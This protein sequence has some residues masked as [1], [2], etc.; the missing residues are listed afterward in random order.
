MPLPG[1]SQAAHRRTGS[2]GR[3][4]TCAPGC[5]GPSAG[6][7]ARGTSPPCSLRESRAAEAPPPAQRRTQHASRRLQELLAAGVLPAVRGAVSCSS[8]LLAISEKRAGG[9][10]QAG[11][12]GVGAPVPGA[13]AAPRGRFVPRPGPVR[14]RGLHLSRERAWHV[15][16]APV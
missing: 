3:A 8:K 13:R 14:L 12:G 2:S 9:G 6:P 15:L 10:V 16:R 1:S 11:P 7:S 5:L 4:W